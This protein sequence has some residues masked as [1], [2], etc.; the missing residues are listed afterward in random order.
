MEKSAQPVSELPAEEEFHP[1]TAEGDEEDKGEETDG[2]E[3]E[4]TDVPVSIGMSSKLAV[5][6]GPK[7]RGT[8]EWTYQLLCICTGFLRLPTPPV[9]QPATHRHTQT[10]ADTHR[11]FGVSASST[12]GLPNLCQLPFCRQCSG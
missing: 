11:H 8:M 9:L 4:A 10:H 7:E 1:D 2:L 6:T 12:L 5:H 3:V